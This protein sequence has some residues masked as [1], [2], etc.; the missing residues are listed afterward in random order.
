MDNLRLDPAGFA[1]NGRER[2]FS[3]G[4]K[5]FSGRAGGPQAEGDRSRMPVYGFRSERAA[6]D[7]SVDGAVGSFAAEGSRGAFARRDVSTCRRSRDRRSGRHRLRDLVSSSFNGG[8]RG[9]RLSVA[10]GTP[11]TYSS[12]RAFRGSSCSVTTST[13]T[14]RS[15]CYRDSYDLS[16]GR[17]KSITS[18]VPGNHEDGVCERLFRL[19]QRRRRRATARPAHAAKVGTA[20]TSAAGT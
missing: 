18:P 10:S 17:I 20:T 4:E 9:P 14:G 11:R 3:S 5:D 16:W 13:K 6:G 8:A 15:P 2:D 7:P 19:L 12:A 1:V